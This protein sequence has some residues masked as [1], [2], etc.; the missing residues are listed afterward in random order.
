MN[1]RKRLI[2]RA[3]WMLAEARRRAA[4]DD[5]LTAQM[6]VG[7]VTGGLAEAHGLYLAAGMSRRAEAVYRLAIRFARRWRDHER[8]GAGATRRGGRR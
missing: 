3:D 2:E 4:I 1:D 5:T 6:L 8:S 7:V